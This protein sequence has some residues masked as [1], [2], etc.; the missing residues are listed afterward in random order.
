MVKRVCKRTSEVVTAMLN[1][2]IIPN[3]MLLTN[4]L[5][6]QAMWLATLFQSIDEY[7]ALVDL[8]FPFVLFIFCII[9]LYY[10]VLFVI[11]TAILY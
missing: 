6:N 2:K 7:I 3:V 9:I 8:F 5:N 11:F 10:F 4:N 1:E